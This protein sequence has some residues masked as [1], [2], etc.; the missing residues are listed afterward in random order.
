MS[1]VGSVGQPIDWPEFWQ[2]FKQYA[3]WDLEWYNGSE[4]VSVK[5]DLA[6]QLSYPALNGKVHVSNSM[7]RWK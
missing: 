3:L 6:V 2:T 1:T 7:E 4:W 5:E